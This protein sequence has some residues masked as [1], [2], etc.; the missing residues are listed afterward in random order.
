[1]TTRRVFEHSG[2]RKLQNS[3]ANNAH[4]LRIKR[5]QPTKKLG[6]PPT[7]KKPKN[8]SKQTPKT[9]GIPLAMLVNQLKETT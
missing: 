1:M 8:Q 7:A 4:A 3:L 9:L 5:T 2:P 6:Q